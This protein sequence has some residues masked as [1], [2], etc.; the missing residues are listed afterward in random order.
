MDKTQLA[1]MWKMPWPVLDVLIG[2]QSSIDLPELRVQ[3]FQEATDFL[4]AYGFDPEIPADHRKLHA[5]LVEALTFI[6]RQLLLPKEWRRGIRPTDDVL[7]CTDV[8]HLLVWAS[9]QSP[10]DHLRR[11]WACAVLRVMH[12]IGHIEGVTRSVDPGVAR[13]QIF[14]R[15]QQHIHRDE[16]GDL[17]LGEGDLKVALARVEWKDTKSR[18]SIIL[19]LL[20][21]RDNVAETLYDYLGIR[22]VTKRLCDVMLVVKCLRRYNMV[23]YPN[24]YPSRARNNLVDLK[25]FRVQIETLRDM[26]T[27]GSISPEEF[28][29][30]VSRLTASAP[31]SL[32]PSN[33]HSAQS[34]RSIQLTGRQRIRV[35]N[36]EFAWLEKLR[37][38]L[39]SQRLSP[40]TANGLTELDQLVTGWYSVRN[41]MEV[42]AFFP[43][44]V[45]IL[46][47][48][49][50]NL[51]A[52]GE[53]NHNRY[54]LSQVRAARK[55]VLSEVLELSRQT[56][57]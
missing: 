6:E 29:R 8:R 13:D 38:A 53:A 25:R 46:D 1:D 18:N 50:Y 15:F 17:W 31:D 44:E 9:S 32:A 39:D 49:S 4:A 34:Y 19:K 11:A 27:A 33:P 47:A 54:K 52:S 45:Q 42:A 7:Y 56:P 16:K 14:A 24:A 30:M 26:L 40:E 23:V 5:I 41:D 22:I 12:T 36:D 3:N 57:L 20:H 28:D 10:E 55:R 43:F 37:R 35:R 48:E 51:A 21:K 2:G